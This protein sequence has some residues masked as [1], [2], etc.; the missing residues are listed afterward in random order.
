MPTVTEAKLQADVHRLRRPTLPTF[1]HVAR[2]WNEEHSKAR[3]ALP[4]CVFK[5]SGT[6]V[7]TTLKLLKW[8]NPAHTHTPPPPPPHHVVA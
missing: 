5:G 8:E 7:T 1:M 2:R 6:L 4:I 3:I